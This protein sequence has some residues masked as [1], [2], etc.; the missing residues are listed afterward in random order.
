[1]GCHKYPPLLLSWSWAVAYRLML[2][3]LCSEE[4]TP[5]TDVY[6]SDTVCHPWPMCHHWHMSDTVSSLSNVITDVCLTHCVITDLCRLTCQTCVCFTQCVIPDLCVS[7]TMCHHWLC[8]KQCVITD[9]CVSHSVPSLTCL[10]YTVCHPWPMCVWHSVHYCVSNSVSSL[11]C[12]CLIQCVLTD[13]CDHWPGCLIQCVLTDQFVSDT[14]SH[15]WLVC[16]ITDPCVSDSVVTDLC[17][18]V[19]HSVSSLTCAP[20]YFLTWRSAGWQSA[21]LLYTLVLSPT[22]ATWPTAAHSPALSEQRSAMQLVPGPY[23][24]WEHYN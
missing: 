13:L 2:G 8:L 12:V 23:T 3:H 10:F 1:M 19:W 20:A 24:L 21:L 9:L 16:V 5:G 18:C 22:A 11:T 4:E 7:D 15:P 6:M 14:V 17:V